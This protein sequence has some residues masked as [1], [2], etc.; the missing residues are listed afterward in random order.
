MKK[1]SYPEKIILF[2]VLLIIAF[3]KSYSQILPDFSD[4]FAHTFSIVARDKVTGDI[5]VAVQS[6]WFNVGAAVPWAEA[7]VGAVATQSLVNVSFGK[8]GLELLKQGKPPKEA[9]DILLSDDP[10]REFRQVAIINAKGEVAAFTGKNCIAEAGHI[11]GDQFSVQAN[12]MLN[13]KVWP[14]MEKAFRQTEGTLAERLVAAL[15]AA[16]QQGGD[17]RGQQSAAVLVVKGN[18]SDKPWEDKLADLRVEDND[19][20]V[21]EIARVLKVQQ[22]YEHMNNGDLAV[23][24]NNDTEALKEYGLAQQMLPDNLETKFW[25]AVSMV[26]MGKADQAMPLFKEIFQKDKNWR[27]LTKRLVPGGF[28]KTDE[29]TLNRIMN[30]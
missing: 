25:A 7:G 20:A 3:S 4:P 16:Q 17:I 2:A 11:E 22:A 6:H 8:R 18:A 19:N 23:E 29:K 24:K 21:N 28:L 27:E 9:L 13:N 10:G 30:L 12:M 1:P 15:Q 5:G 26:N 14:A